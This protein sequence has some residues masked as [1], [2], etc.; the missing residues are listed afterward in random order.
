MPEET[1]VQIVEEE[2]LPELVSVNGEKFELPSRLPWGKEKRVLSLLGKAIKHIFP[3][4]EGQDRSAQVHAVVTEF[5]NFVGARDGKLAQQLQPYI[6]EYLSNVPNTPTVDV[7]RLLSFFA[8][9]APDMM[10][11]LVAIV[12]GK[13]VEYIDEHLDGKSVVSFSLP[14]IMR[15]LRRY[16][17]SFGANVTT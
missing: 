4:G 8:Q 11:E 2:Q 13:S 1:T 5:A 14:Y 17:Q 12:T 7:F 9:D 6:Q 15:A 3:Q 10:T 16:M